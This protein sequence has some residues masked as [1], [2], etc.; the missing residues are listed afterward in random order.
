MILISD[1]IKSCEDEESEKENLLHLGAK[2]K[3]ESNS[4]LKSNYLQP[5]NPANKV[6]VTVTSPK[7]KED[8]SESESEDVCVGTVSNLKEPVETNEGEEFDEA[9]LVVEQSE[10]NEEEPKELEIYKEAQESITKEKKQLSKGKIKN[11]VTTTKVTKILTETKSLQSKLKNADFEEN[12][13]ESE[14]LELKEDDKIISNQFPKSTSFYPCLANHTGITIRITGAD[15]IESVDSESTDNEVQIIEKYNYHQNLDMKQDSNYI[16]IRLSNQNNRSKVTK[17]QIS[18]QTF[19]LKGV[20]SNQSIRSPKHNKKLESRQYKKLS[21]KAEESGEMLNICT[22]KQVINKT[23]KSE[24]NK[25][26]K[27]SYKMK[28]SFYHTNNKSKALEDKN[29]EDCLKCVK[30][31]RPKSCVEKGS[32]KVVM[33]GL[34]PVTAP[35]KRPCCPPQPHLPEY[36]GLR[37]EYGLSAEQLAERKRYDLPIYFQCRL[38]EYLCINL[39]GHYFVSYLCSTL[40]NFH[41]L[42]N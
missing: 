15:S 31:V 41:K 14:K 27:H 35:A 26:D 16:P 19:I 12:I 23:E 24:S 7:R 36:N 18:E 38:V 37:S 4:E 22:N 6:V 29:R 32:T 10:Y 17:L 25:V 8:Q 30:K 13:Q 33:K 9:S 42:L 20:K 3:N 21:S 5:Q 34:R 40:L 2:Q 11:V 39:K 1:S 28:N